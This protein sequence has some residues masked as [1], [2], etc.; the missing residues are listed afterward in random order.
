[1]TLK[2]SDVTL[3]FIVLL[4]SGLYGTF[5]V[6]ADE[7]DDLEAGYLVNTVSTFLFL[8]VT[9]NWMTFLSSQT[10]TAE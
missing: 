3:S 8:S 2:D 5:L 4:A 1:M 7:D 6:A 10:L 9:T